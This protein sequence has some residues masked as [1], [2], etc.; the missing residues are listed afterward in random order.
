MS[1][2][3]TFMNWGISQFTKN[4]MGGGNG[5]NGGDNGFWSKVISAG[6]TTLSDKLIGMDKPSPKIRPGDVDL[7]VTAASTYSMSAAKG[8]DTPEVADYAA[9]EAKWT[10]IAKRLG[11]IKDTTAIGS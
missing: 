5:G 3:S 11:D 8:P 7:G 10:R 9:I 4:F 2:G 6:A 1:W